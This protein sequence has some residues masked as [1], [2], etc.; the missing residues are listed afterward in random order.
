[1]VFI[2]IGTWAPDFDCSSCSDRLLISPDYLDLSEVSKDLT[3][4]SENKEYQAMM[5]ALLF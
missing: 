4:G 5:P 3:F 1:M 2:L